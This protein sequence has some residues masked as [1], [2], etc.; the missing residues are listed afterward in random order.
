[1]KKLFRLVVL[2]LLFSLFFISPV[3]ASESGKHLHL[4]SDTSHEGH[5]HEDHS[6][7]E[8]FGD[9]NMLYIPCSGTGVKHQLTGRGQAQVPMSNG[10][11]Y[12]A[13]LYQ[14]KG[15]SLGIVTKT[16][17]YAIPKASSPGQYVAVTLPYQIGTGYDLTNKGKTYSFSYASSWYSGYF[18]NISF[19]RS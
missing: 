11:K 8:E 12:V 13:G 3:S 17:P 4:E 16:L 10:T 6:H 15:C 19:V 7:A 2:G 18:A 1:M 5:S 14:C 9:I